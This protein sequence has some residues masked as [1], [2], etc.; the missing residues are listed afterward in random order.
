MIPKSEIIR[1]RS[2]RACQPGKQAQCDLDLTIRAAF[3]AVSLTNS[4]FGASAHG[5]N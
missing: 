2:E 4:R 3:V 1:K 5:A